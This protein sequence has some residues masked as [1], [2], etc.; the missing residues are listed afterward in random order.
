[1]VVSNNLVCKHLTMKSRNL[2]S[3]L[4]R[5]I[6]KQFVDLEYEELCPI[7]KEELNFARQSQCYFVIDGVAM[8]F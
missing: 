3:S 6:N 7:D 2:Y 5:L 8:N 1:M 4:I